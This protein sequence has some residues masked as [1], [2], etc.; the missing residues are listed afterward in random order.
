MLGWKAAMDSIEM[1][2]PEGGIGGIGEGGIGGIGGQRGVW[3]FVTTYPR[4][5]TKSC[6]CSY[7]KRIFVFGGVD[8]GVALNTWD[9]YDVESG[10]WTS[11]TDNR[12]ESGKLDGKFDGKFDGK[13]SD[14]SRKDGENE[15]DCNENDNDTIR[16]IDGYHSSF[17]KVGRGLYC[18]V[19][20]TLT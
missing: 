20:V 8:M 13:E 12:T 15:E 6:C 14:M 16:Q 1:Y 17:Q 10:L 9:A 4:K 5:R 2:D 19:A 7:D 11:E 3:K 18:A